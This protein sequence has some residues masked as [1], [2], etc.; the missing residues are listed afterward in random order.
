MEYSQ[1]YTQKFKSFRELYQYVSDK[2]ELFLQK[3]IYPMFYRDKHGETH[4]FKYTFPIVS[5][6]YSTRN[7]KYV[8]DN[9][10]FTIV[11]FSYIYADEDTDEACWEVSMHIKDHLFCD[12]PIQEFKSWYEDHY[13]FVWAEMKGMPKRF[14]F[15]KLNLNSKEVDDFCI[16][17]RNEERDFLLF[18]LF[19]LL[20]IY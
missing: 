1:W 5:K 12:I 16:E 2:E 3:V 7:P 13:Q 8:I 15:P 20:R 18:K 17:F 4:L 19:D 6:T 11:F 9:E 10:Y 14:C